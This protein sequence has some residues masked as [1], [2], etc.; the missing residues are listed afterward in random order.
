MKS[1]MTIQVVSGIWIAWFT[2]HLIVESL[3]LVKV[4]LM[5]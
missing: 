2:P 5:A 1:M 3:A 4:M